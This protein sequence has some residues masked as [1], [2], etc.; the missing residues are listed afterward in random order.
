MSPPELPRRRLRRL[1]RD[2]IASLKGDPKNLVL[3]LKIAFVLQQLER[4]TEAIEIYQG[5]ARAF[6]QAGRLMQAIAVCKGILEI[7][8]S[9][10]QTQEMLAELCEQ[11]RPGRR[12]PALRMQRRGG[13]WIAIP[14]ADRDLLSGLDALAGVAVPADLP[15]PEGTT[16]VVAASQDDAARVAWPSIQ[17]GQA[18]HAA[19]SAVPDGESAPAE[20][21]TRAGR[22]A[23]RRP[24]PTTA[25]R[26]TRELDF[27]E[28]TKALGRGA[29]LLDLPPEPY[30]SYEEPTPEELEVE[31]AA[32]PSTLRKQVMREVSDLR[33]DTPGP[34]EVTQ[35]DAEPASGAEAAADP[36]GDA[37]PRVAEPDE[38]AMVDSLAKLA[39]PEQPAEP[40]T[41]L[42]PL[43]SDLPRAAFVELLGRMT[44]R[45]EPAGA[46]IVRDG[47]PGDALYVV[48]TGSVRVRKRRPDGGEAE[49]ARLGQGSFFGELGLLGDQTR[50]ATVI[51]A[52]EV[53]LF[54]LP[55][56][57]MADLAASHPGV[58]RTLQHFYR[59]RLLAML[60]QTCP[61][62]VPLGEEEREQVAGRLLMRRFVRGERIV[63][64]GRATEG[65]YLI[66]TGAVDVSIVAKGRELE[67]G[68][69]GD[70]SYF[71]ELSLL[72][73][74][75][76]SATVRAR[77]T[78]ELAHLPAG[79][80]YEIMAAHPAVWEQIRAEAARREAA[81]ASV[82]HG[83][84]A[85]T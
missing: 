51:A 35:V 28:E 33:I 1:L 38:Q 4:S 7:D 40:A 32:S 82:L 68:R 44:V 34:G 6:A 53:E 41:A 5:V 52:E 42:M 77:G 56:A 14:V 9:H 11:K 74:G 37:T 61:L 67:V 16:D 49:L 12:T 79:D 64:Q 30:G 71:G 25:D 57:V 60:L 27:P 26:E 8:P 72:R 3:R 20:S 78:T 81:T 75:V 62:F 69:L 39:P 84:A 10:R 63:E 73:G 54:E 65:L 55:R 18:F 15:T 46:V 83:R 13:R 29:M 66:L 85:L 70:G 59:E 17:S 47:E 23:P 2:Y 31:R 43:F 80:F 76:A 21:A 24:T 50:H 58:L 19:I 36:D 22:S 48:T 45:Q